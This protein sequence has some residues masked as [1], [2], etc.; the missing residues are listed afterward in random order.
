[1]KIKG[2]DK[3][4]EGFQNHVGIMG[5]FKERSVASRE[6]VSKSFRIR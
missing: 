4:V 5:R 2:D 1:M 3:K 6:S